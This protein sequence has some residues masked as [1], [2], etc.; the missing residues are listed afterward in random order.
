MLPHRPRTGRRQLHV[1]ISGASGVRVTFDADGHGRPGPEHAGHLVEQA[2]A[3]RLDRRLVGVEEDLLLE[4]DLLLRDDDVL[5][6]LGATVVVGGARLVRALVGRVGHAVLVVVGIGAAVLV[7]EAV[8]VL[9]I[10]WA[11]VA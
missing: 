5:V 3:A 7:L 10:V 4:L 9:G 6:L 1:V 8:L 11:L 2:E